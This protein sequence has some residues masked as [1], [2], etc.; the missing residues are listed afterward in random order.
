MKTLLLPL[1]ISIASPSS[2]GMDWMTSL[3][4]A[5]AESL[6]KGKPLLVD[7][8]AVWCY[9]C[10]FMDEHVLSGK[11]FTQM[12]SSFVP[13]KLDVDTDEGGRFKKEHRIGFL[14][15][16]LVLTPD[17]REMGRILGEQ[18]EEDFIAR[19]RSILSAEGSPARRLA[20]LLDANEPGKAIELR[21]SASKKDPSLKK[22][23]AWRL[24]AARLDFG[25]ARKKEDAG[26]ALKHL[27]T[28]IDLDQSCRMV[29]P[30]S[31][32]LALAEKTKQKGAERVWEKARVRLSFLAEERVFGPSEARCADRRSVV[33]TLAA[34]YSALG[35]PERKKQV[36]KRMAEHLNKESKG[37]VGEDRNLD[38]DLRYFLGLAG[39][40]EALEELFAV[41][42]S[43]YPTDYVYPYRFAGFLHKKK[44]LKEAKVWADKAFLLSY[45][46]NRIYAS[47]LQARI[48]GSQGKIS[49]ARRI[50]EREIRVNKKRFPDETKRLADQL[51]AL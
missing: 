13:L 30:V 1:L 20:D 5:Q 44:R 29:Y 39:M 9:S 24:Q 12:A 6:R 36:F 11:P 47:S 28:I 2:A 21:D 32:A 34:V 35:E 17:G 27:E 48:L 46:I 38:D 37:Q 31:R 3:P 51:K 10:Y 4:E 23:P 18:T 19:L 26:A 49:D 42:I 45:G 15:S 50:L 14:P 43:E 22:D 40:D 33:T 8:Q 16:Y 41:L 25:L 7:F